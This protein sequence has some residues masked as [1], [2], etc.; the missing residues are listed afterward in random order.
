M[1]TAASPGSPVPGGSSPGAAGHGG[2]P[3]IAVPDYWWYRARSRLLEAALGAFVPARARA[4]DVGSADGPSAQWFRTRADEVVALDIDVRGLS[5]DGVCG[6]A[7]ALPFADES[8]DVIA[9]FDVI[10]HCEP[11]SIT[12]R[13]L[14]RV[15]RPGGVL[16]VSVPAY[17]WAWSDHDE[18]NGHH[19]RYTRSRIVDGLTAA[20]FAVDRA[21]YAFTSVFP[22]FAAERAVRR[23]RARRAT[24]AAD[25]VEVPA[26]PRPVHHALLG[27]C[28]LDELLL[29]GRDLPFG[30]SVFVAAHLPAEAS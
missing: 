4:L 1:T 24:E 12:L 2:S 9:A 6:S 16:V 23:L 17:Q 25:I 30:S 7:V 20:G 14:R 15:L 8:F 28:R 19:R 18:A 21:T 26:L 5:A 11:E 22:M 13:E 3:S 10:E 27:L 29:A